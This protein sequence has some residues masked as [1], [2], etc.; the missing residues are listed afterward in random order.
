MKSH[1]G[2]IVLVGLAVQRLR[3]QWANLKGA[4]R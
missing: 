3:W 1:Q 2:L 4:I